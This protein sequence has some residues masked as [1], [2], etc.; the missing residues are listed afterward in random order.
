MLLGPA[1]SLFPPSLRSFLLPSQRKKAG[2]SGSGAGTTTTAST[3]SQQELST[4]PSTFGESTLLESEEDED[5]DEVDFPDSDEEE[6]DEETALLHQEVTP[7][8][9]CTFFVEH[10]QPFFAALPYIR[11]YVVYCTA[12]PEVKYNVHDAI[13]VS[14]RLPLLLAPG[15]NRRAIWTSE[16]CA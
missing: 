14:R 6:E 1:H 15:G 5:M 4:V 11:A 10:S 7:P 3:I 13:V 12:I 2:L 8:E 9:Y 16:N